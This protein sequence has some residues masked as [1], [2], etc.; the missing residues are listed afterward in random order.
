MPRALQS[1]RLIFC[2]T[3]GRRMCHQY[4]RKSVQSNH[5]PR[6]WRSQKKG[7]QAKKEQIES[8]S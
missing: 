8:A 1:A 3:T 4:R 6:S 7:P 5:K 2:Y